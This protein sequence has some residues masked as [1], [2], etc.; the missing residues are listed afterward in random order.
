MKLRRS[1]V[2]LIHFGA[3]AT[4]AM[5]AYGLVFGIWY[6]KPL[7]GA[8]GVTSIFL[9]LLGVDVCLGPI[10]TFIVYRPG[11]PRVRMDLAIIVAV[12]ILAFGYGM[13]SVAMAR[14]VWL[15]FNVNRFSLEQANS[16]DLSHVQHAAS[17]YR[18]TPWLGPQWV[19][20]KFPEQRSERN[21]LL[22]ESVQGGADLP[23]R[24]DLFVPLTAEADALRQHARPM[25][26]LEKYN[27][28]AVVHAV[29]ADAPN[30]DGWLPLVVRGKS[31]VAC[32]DQKTL[33][34][35]KVLDLAPF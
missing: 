33:T 35:F 16:L 5:L 26:L 8:V 15:V 2:S 10:L 6:P 14:P 24:P 22:F 27:D 13:F 32:F 21:K 3:S 25:D 7:A 4:M 12:Q 28:A 1:V 20:A 17:D 30:C 34:Y 18:H 19:A 11:K 23:Q 29:L 31:K 9:L